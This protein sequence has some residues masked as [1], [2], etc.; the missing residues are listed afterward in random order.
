MIVTT[1]ADCMQRVIDGYG[2]ECFE[3]EIEGWFNITEARLLVAC[4]AIPHEIVEV[5]LDCFIHQAKQ[6]RVWE[7]E[8]VK[9]MPINDDPGLFVH[10]DDGTHM[11]ADGI[12]RALSR[13]AAG[14]KLMKFAFIPM[15]FMPRPRKDFAMTHDWGDDLKNGKIIK[16]GNK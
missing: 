13:H 6:S 12:H 7:P 3:H 5:E 14:L 11:M 10:C 15:R 16:R 8:R 4:N 1:K 2:F 9:Q